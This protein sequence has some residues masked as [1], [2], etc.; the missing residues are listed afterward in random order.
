MHRI[1]IKICK[2]DIRDGYKLT[3]SKDFIFVIGVQGLTSVIMAAR[4]DVSANKSVE[5]LKY[6][7]WTVRL[8]G[9]K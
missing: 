1:Y 3:W 9:V 7:M 6:S 4:S 8:S 5:E 2:R